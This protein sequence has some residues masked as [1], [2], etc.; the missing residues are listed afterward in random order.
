MSYGLHVCCLFRSQEETLLGKAQLISY[1]LHFILLTSALVNDAYEDVGNEVLD[2]TQ[3]PR[4]DKMRTPI[5][6]KCAVITCREKLPIGQV[7]H[8]HP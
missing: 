2:I 8:S 6:S 3:G 1:K 5:P 4:I 7:P